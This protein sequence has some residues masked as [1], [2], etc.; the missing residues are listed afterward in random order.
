[1]TEFAAKS[2]KKWGVFSSF[3]EGL[4]RYGDH[5]LMHDTN[6]GTKIERKPG[7]RQMLGGGCEC[8]KIVMAV[9]G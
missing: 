6:T 9:V 8:Q 4:Q 1:L 3:N 5:F 2:Q 7:A